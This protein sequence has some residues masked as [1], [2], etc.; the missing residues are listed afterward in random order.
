MSFVV[1]MLSSSSSAAV[2]LS[3]AG[4]C[5]IIFDMILVLVSEVKVVKCYKTVDTWG[6]GIH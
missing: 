2:V 1:H 3:M 5:D 4:W 6:P